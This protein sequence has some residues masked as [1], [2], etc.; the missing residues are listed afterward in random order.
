MR[1]TPRSI[2]IALALVAVFSSTGRAQSVSDVVEQMYASY[3]RQAAG[4][5]NYTIVQTAMG[6]QSTSYFEKESVDGH[7]V[8]KMRSG[9]AAANF[10]VGI[11]GGDTGIGD[12]YELGPELIEHAQYAGREQLDGNSVHVLAIDDL[13]QV[14][15]AQQ[16]APEEMD[17]EAK[18]GRV[19]VDT[20]MLVPRKLVFV[21]DASMPTGKHEVTVSITFEDIRDVQGL[22]IPYRTVMEISGLQAMMD[23]ETQAQLQQMEQQLAALPPDQREMMER[24]LGPQIEQLR[25]MASGNGDAMSIDITVDDVQVNSG[26]PR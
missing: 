10:D 26:A 12:I 23:P 19:Y 15:L 25:Q 8:F 17:F 16:T 11:S 21:G 2:P 18:S 1:R 4:V 22:L 14:D 5:E 3:E 9:S 6:M 13:S 20:E 7:P 24:M